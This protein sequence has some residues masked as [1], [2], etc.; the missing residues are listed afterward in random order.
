MPY[1][2]NY[3]PKYIDQTEYFVDMPIGGAKIEMSLGTK[4]LTFNP[5]REKIGF[6][7]LDDLLEIQSYI[8]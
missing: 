3:I 7:K 2:S 6:L 4:V 8:I 1:K 5:D